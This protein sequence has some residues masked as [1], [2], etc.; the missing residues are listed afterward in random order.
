MGNLRDSEKVTWKFDLI[1][2]L[3][4][5]YLQVKLHSS[6]TR[7]EMESK[8]EERRGEEAGS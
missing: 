3:R 7:H 2:S 4:F 5:Y 8:G 1:Y 6:F